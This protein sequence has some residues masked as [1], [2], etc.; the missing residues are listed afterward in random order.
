MEG[1]SVRLRSAGD[2]PGSQRRQPWIDPLPWRGLALDDGACRQHKNRQKFQNPTIIHPHVLPFR[3]DRVPPPPWVPEPRLE[4]PRCL[5]GRRQKSSSSDVVR[6]MFV[7]F[8]GKKWRAI[9]SL[10]MDD[11]DGLEFMRVHVITNRKSA[12]KFL[13]IF[14]RAFPRLVG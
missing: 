8:S 12:G 11:V 6:F 7:S 1:C 3:W 10:L 13:L 14:F 9:P 4:L 5:T 2:E